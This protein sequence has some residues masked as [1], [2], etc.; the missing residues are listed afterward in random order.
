MSYFNQILGGNIP[1]TVIQSIEGFQQDYMLNKELAHYQ[2]NESMANDLGNYPVNGHK[3]ISS[4]YGS[5]V[6][7]SLEMD[8]QKVGSGLMYI[9]KTTTT[10]ALIISRDNL[11]KISKMGDK[12]SESD[13]KLVADTVKKVSAD[14][15]Q[16]IVNIINGLSMNKSMKELLV[17]SI[18]LTG[19]TSKN[20]QEMEAS[21]KQIVMI[22][23]LH[24]D[25][26]TRKE[27]DILT[28]LKLKLTP[29][30]LKKC[31][32]E[33]ARECV[34]DD[35]FLFKFANALM[36]S[37]EHVLGSIMNA[38]KYDKVCEF[39]AFSVELANQ[40]SKVTDI[41][42]KVI[43][44]IMDAGNSTKLTDSTKI[45][46]LKEINKNIDQ[47][48]V[49]GG[50]S[51][52]ISDVINDVVS[53]N[54]SDLLRTIAVSNK[55]AISGAKGAS[56]SFKNISQTVQM[57]TKVE[58]DFA[59]K[60]ASKIQNEIANKVK[61]NI[62]S[63]TKQFEKDVSK[64][65]TNEKA[66][67]N[68]GGVIGGV[69]N[70]LGGAFGKAMDT[71]GKVL[72]VSAGN[73]MEQT[74]TKD[75]T[76]EMKD[77]FNLNNSFKYDKTDEAKNAISNVLK[78]ENLSKCAADSKMANEIDLGKIDVT[79]PIEI[80][81]IKQE[82]IVKDVMKCA[83]SQ[84][85]INDIS[86][87]VFNDYDKLITALIENVNDKLTDEEKTAVQGDIYAIGTAG[88]AVLESTGKAVKDV[89]EGVSTAAQGAGKGISTAS[90]GLGKGLST[91]AEGVGKGVSDILG[92]LTAP[93]IVGA[94]ILALLLIGYVMFKF[95]GA[96]SLD[97]E[98]IPGASNA[99]GSKMSSD[100]DD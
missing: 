78:V 95:L 48:K 90:E 30:N 68:I 36:T 16:S 24:H 69:V 87:K 74:T 45:K 80:E 8:R 19:V 55:I 18:H 1:I 28:S 92:G 35:E 100:D 96:P 62:N 22:M 23:E 42:P 57:E 58:A 89:G 21:R 76:Q 27:I 72:S 15:A 85:V 88:A 40:L 91:V 71:V 41:K 86:L 84:E 10:E 79:G 5:Y 63:T 56:F 31:G 9:L 17:H 34:F 83:F 67:T 93:L 29:E 37:L 4:Q 20:K 43:E 11:N 2:I 97:D 66:G 77:T 81:N 3:I 51:K 12:L 39:Y 53:K 44:T 46:D 60:I 33:L 49:I 61:D 54:S 13:S 52:M 98:G 70:A 64:L 38:T 73:S 47:N 75:I 65:K 25:F 82:S 14:L 32:S 6:V 50:M 59:Q 7:A 26:R 94:I 99:I